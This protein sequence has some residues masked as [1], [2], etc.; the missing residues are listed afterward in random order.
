MPKEVKSRVQEFRRAYRPADLSSSFG[1][2]EYD[3]VVKPTVMPVLPMRREF[4]VLDGA[5]DR[6]L[7]GCV[8]FAVMVRVICR[9]LRVH[10]RDVVEHHFSG[11]SNMRRDVSR[12]LQFPLGKGF[13]ESFSFRVI[14]FAILVRVKCRYFREHFAEMLRY[15]GR[16]SV[17]LCYPV[18]QAA[19]SM[20]LC[21][22]QPANGE[23][24]HRRYRNWFDV[25][26]IRCS[27]VFV[28][29]RGNR[30]SPGQVAQR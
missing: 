17:M 16:I 13:P 6:S 12:K 26:H 21:D 8:E 10:F 18:T 2:D 27:V 22:C 5:F 20:D 19:A 23:T 7:L 11:F 9:D 28:S 1:L 29:R 4:P 3:S 30:V 25:F 24:E 14:E 15:R